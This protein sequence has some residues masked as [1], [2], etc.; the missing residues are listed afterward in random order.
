MT[1]RPE[2]GALPPTLRTK[3]L[4]LGPLGRAQLEALAVALL[5]GPVE[6]AVVDLLEGR[7]DGNPFFAEQLLVYL[8]EQGQLVQSGSGWRLA[9]A[10]L[11]PLPD[12]L[13]ALLVARLD[14]L[15]REIRETVQTAA[16]LGREFEVRLLSE[17]LRGRAV[18][19]MVAAAERQAIWAALT[20]LK[21]L[22]RHALLR[23]AAYQMQVSSRRQ[24]LHALAVTALENLYR[25]D[26]RARYGELAYHAEQA[27]LQEKARVYLRL[28]AD[29]ARETYL[30]ASAIEHYTRLLALLP[31]EAQAERWEVIA[32]RES[33]Y[34]VIARLDERLADIAALE[35]LADALDDDGMRAD[36][37]YR[38]GDTLLLQGQPDQAI[39]VSEQA[40]ALSRRSGRRDVEASAQLVI[41]S[42]LMRRG[43][44]PA[45]RACFAEAHRLGHELNNLLLQ[46]KALGVDGLAAIMQGDLEHGRASH[47]QACEIAWSI[48]DER[49]LAKALNNLAVS[50]GAVG[51]LPR[52]L[53]LYGE[54]LDLTRLLGDISGEAIVLINTGWMATQVGN[55]DRADA[56]FKQAL[57]LFREAREL[58]DQESVWVN[59]AIAAEASGNYAEAERCVE[60]CLLLTPKLGNR[61]ME[62]YALTCQAY[63]FCGTG[64][65][66]EALAPAQAALELRRALGNEALV[67]EALGALCHVYLELGADAEAL[68]TAETLLAGLGGPH[69]ENRAALNGTE[70]PLRVIWGCYRALQAAADPRAAQVI[71]AARAWLE[72]MAAPFTGEAA[73]MSL[74]D[75]V[76]WHRAIMEQAARLA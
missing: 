75:N 54:A 76:P 30:N 40:I 26:L 36:A 67:L 37:A 43:E 18:A 13:Q 62:A 21:Y 2:P 25:D 46:A 44:Y 57:L 3:E 19:E 4:L 11:A 38:R 60:Q 15:G 48:G 58:P 69:V 47:E 7:A 56:D 39:A 12:G 55:Y 28:A 63:V 59:M 17:M 68:S 53:A 61:L 65:P 10:G 6:P 23:D 49:Q 45:A 51:D 34:A 72:D 14:R 33:V 35:Q 50:V 70:Q 42:L 64:R 31:S 27:G 52:A 24:A 1:G 66:E 74:L 16:V 71:A 5:G 9:E 41:G 73:R 32:V 29:A 8:Q 22:F 20:E